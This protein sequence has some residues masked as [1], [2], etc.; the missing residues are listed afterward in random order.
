ATKYRI[1]RV[2]TVINKLPKDDLQVLRDRGMTY[3]QIAEEMKK[4]MFRISPSSVRRFLLR[5]PRKKKDYSPRSIPRHLHEGVKALVD[6]LYEQCNTQTTQQIIE[7]VEHKMGVKIKKDVIANIRAELGL[8]QYR[9]RYGHAVRIVN[10]LLRIIY[11]EKKLEAGEHFLIHSFSDESYFVLGRESSH[12][13]VRSR[14]A[15]IKQAPKHAAKVLV[16]GAISVRGPSPCVILSG[17]D[18]IVDSPQ[19]QKILHNH[20]IQWNRDT[21]GGIGILVQ[22][23]APC[24]V[25]RCTRLYFERTGIQKLI[26][27]IQKKMKQVLE[28]RGEP[29]PD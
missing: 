17:K 7:S 1:P 16:W 11:V 15:A 29:C 3:K 19:Y 13:F 27:R 28:K 14:A 6:G 26:A 18:S 4:R 21:F 12:C 10:R 25:S 24:H 2:S 9:V 5:K 8:Y 20:F 23:A 22:D